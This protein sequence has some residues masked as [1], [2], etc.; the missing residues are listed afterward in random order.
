[1]THPL[2]TIAPVPDTYTATCREVA[3]WHSAQALFLLGRADR[4]RELHGPAD[5]VLGH[6]LDMAAAQTLI[7]RAL[8][9]A[10]TS[11][12]PDQ[13]ARAVLAAGLAGDDTPGAA[14][15][16]AQWAGVDAS[17]GRRAGYES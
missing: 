7:A 6:L 16:I 3:G 13:I 12:T 5:T 4:R 10:T 9:G 15:C 1:M 8:Y 17:K 11:S 14:G 2:D